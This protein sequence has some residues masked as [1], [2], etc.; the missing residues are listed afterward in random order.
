[1]IGFDETMLNFAKIKVAG[2][3]GGGVEPVEAA[4]RQ[5]GQRG[6][7]GGEAGAA[8]GVG[9]RLLAGGGLLDEVDG[10]DVADE[11]GAPVFEQ[12]PGEAGLVDR[13]RAGGLGGAGVGAHAHRLVHRGR[14]GGLQGRA[15][16]EA[17]DQQGG[18]AVKCA[19]DGCPRPAYSEVSLPSMLSEVEMAR[20]LSS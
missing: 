9:R 19:H 7:G 11:A 12:G 10:D 1:M 3:G 16:G 14:R 18:Q 17:G 2:V 20:E 13:A 15:A 5:L 8:L 4:Q 6:D